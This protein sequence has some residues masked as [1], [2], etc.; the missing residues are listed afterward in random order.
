[1][2]DGNYVKVTCNADHNYAVAWEV[3]FD[4]VCAGNT[5]EIKKLGKDALDV[6]YI[7]PMSI[8][9]NFSLTNQTETKLKTIPSVVSLIESFRTT[10][11]ANLTLSDIGR[12]IEYGNVGNDTTAVDT[13][14]YAFGSTS[15]F[16]H[17]RLDYI[18]VTWSN[19]L[20]E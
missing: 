5:W 13:D 17:E 6:F 18:K 16:W 10:N 2:T 7:S 12:L 1:V 15:V 11:R 14:G 9:G 8:G 20:D 19:F 3:A 4:I